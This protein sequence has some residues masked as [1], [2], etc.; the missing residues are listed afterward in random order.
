MIPVSE[1]S[2]LRQALSFYRRHWLHIVVSPVLAIVAITF[3]HE[4]A[5][6]LAAWLQGGTITS[7]RFIPD[8]QNFGSVSYT[9]ALGAQFSAG[10]IS[11]APYLFWSLVATATALIA[12]R[13]TIPG[14][15]APTLFVWFYAA[16]I[17]DIAKS[18]AEFLLGQPND[19]FHAL[20]P[21]SEIYELIIVLLAAGVFVV[22]YFV[23]R[24]VYGHELALSPRG[25]L[26]T[27]IAA[28]CVIVLMFGAIGLL[29][30]V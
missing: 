18:C 24:K 5:H 1:Q 16:P 27:S 23:Q 2:A 28:V 25:Y 17:L 6:A 3:F 11:L 15:L 29:S 26:A 30:I 14:K 4:A 19:L 20:G 9:F 21:V 10:L 12:W 22:S 8:G 13:F 7:F